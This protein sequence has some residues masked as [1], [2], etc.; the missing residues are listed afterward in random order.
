MDEDILKQLE[1]YYED[2]LPHYPIEDTGTA[3]EVHVRTCRTRISAN[4]P[5][6]RFRLVRRTARVAAR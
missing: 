4:R 6:E 2:T 5:S 1:E 3:E